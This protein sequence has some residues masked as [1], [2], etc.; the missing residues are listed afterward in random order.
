M[1]D[2]SS[3]YEHDDCE[4]SSEA[5]NILHEFYEAN[6]IVYVEGV[7]DIC[8]WDTVLSKFNDYKY[9]VL[10]VGGCENLKPYIEKVLNNE[11]N[12]L[13][14]LDSDF[15]C[16]L[17]GKYNH[18]RIIYTYGYSIENTY[19]SVS[20]VSKIIKSLARL[21]ARSI[22]EIT[23]KTHEW[24]FSFLGNISTL[25]KVD[26]CN[27]LYEKGLTVLGDT[28]H[29]FLIN[30]N[31]PVI[32]SDKVNQ[33]IGRILEHIPEYSE[34]AIDRLLEEKEKVLVHCVRGHFL[35]SAISNYIR[36]VV[37]GCGRKLSLS[38]DSLYVNFIAIFDNEFNETHPEYTYYQNVV[39]N[40]VN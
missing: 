8:F 13:V 5:E 30:E 35:Y 31:V 27:A 1:V 34:D 33:H 40:A 32:S 21:N 29:R 15:N 2:Y 38:N 28:V 4:Y 23:D 6:F 20:C 37:F 36:H 22:L 39:N 11:I 12:C 7:D 10:D 9:E 3:S 26:I 24:F 17:D 16:I 19:I 25:V 14:A 18:N